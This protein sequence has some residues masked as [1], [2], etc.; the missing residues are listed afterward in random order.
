MHWVRFPYPLGWTLGMFFSHFW[1]EGIKCPP[2]NF[3][4]RWVGLTSLCGKEGATGAS[5]YLN[6]ELH[7]KDNLDFLQGVR[8][9]RP[10]V[11]LS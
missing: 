9:Q 1:K 7:K 5:Y 4:R 2:Y 8:W 6:I 10:L 11:T 3:L